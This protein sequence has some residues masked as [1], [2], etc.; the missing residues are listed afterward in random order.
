MR[1]IGVVTVARSDY[2]IYLPILRR[3]EQDPD[4]RLLLFVG[5]MHLEPKFGLTVQAIEDDGFTIAARI[6]MQLSSDA[7]EGIA[8][9][10]GVG[11]SGFAQAY[12]EHRPDLLVVLGDRFEMLAAVSSALPFRIPLAHIHGGELSEGAIDD[13]I[14]HAIT[15]MSH[16]HFVAMEAYAQRVMQMGEEAWRVT[17]CGAPGLDNL[18][19]IELLSREDLHARHG[20]DP[21][22]EFLLVTYHPVTLEADRTEDQISNLLDALDA[23]DGNIVFTYP[24]ADT[25]SSIIIQEI[26]HYVETHK[27]S[28]CIINL[29][30]VGYYSMMQHARAMVGNSS[31]GIIEAASFKLPVVNIGNRQRG[32]VHGENVIDVGYSRDEILAGIRESTSSEFRG[33]L[34]SV[35]NPY[36]DGKATE[37][38]ITKLKEIEINDR[39]F[40]KRFQDTDG[41]G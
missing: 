13:A 28:L 17:V 10:M 40:Q 16:L 18:Q 25:E 4:L 39:L 27:N 26:E 38:I 9:S 24:N 7:P 37:K 1:S 2:S 32:R 33:K 5:G 20:L 36:G 23:W 3:I 41:A 15:K 29:G 31:S 22:S 19:G 35:V 21:H 34:E 12:A 6:D 30:T 11:I 8:N 14:R